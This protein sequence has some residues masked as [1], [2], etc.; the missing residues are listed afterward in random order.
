LWRK[1]WFGG[2]RL[3]LVEEGFV[4]LE[5]VRF[6]G[7]MSGLVEEGLVPIVQEGTYCSE[8]ICGVWLRK[9]LFG[10]GNFS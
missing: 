1:V 3:G 9:V 6:G 10:C 4:W 2:G 8:V 7:R 5:K